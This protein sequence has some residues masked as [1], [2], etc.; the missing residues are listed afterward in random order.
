MLY[1][2][3]MSVGYSKTELELLFP[4]LVY[5]QYQNLIY[6]LFIRIITL[7]SKMYP[8]LINHVCHAVYVL[9]CQPLRVVSLS[10]CLTIA[11]R[12]TLLVHN[13]VG[14]LGCLSLSVQSSQA[15]VCPFYSLIA[16][17]P[18]S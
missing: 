6:A 1:T 9:L 5:S 13:L 7:L 2:I 14:H 16:F 17:I 10:L 11:S 15:V 4:T 8:K 12:I 18:L 3:W